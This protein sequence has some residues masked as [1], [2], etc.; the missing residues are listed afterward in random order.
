MNKSI[1]IAACLATCGL[2]AQAQSN[3]QFTGLVDMYAGSMKAPGE[4]TSQTKINSGG[5]TTSWWGMMG[6][7]DLGG[8]LKG[9]VRISVC[10]A[11]K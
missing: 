1:V 5:M 7:E 3:V 8:G 11:G 2:A 6:S 4:A 9:S 10:R